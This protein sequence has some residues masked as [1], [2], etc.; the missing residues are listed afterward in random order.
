MIAMIK[1]VAAFYIFWKEIYL[2]RQGAVSR[3]NERVPGRAGSSDLNDALLGRVV[4]E[5]FYLDLAAGR[6]V[7]GRAR[8]GLGVHSYSLDDLLVLGLQVSVDTRTAVPTHT[9]TVDKHGCLTKINGITCIIPGKS[10][11]LSR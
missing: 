10:A 11:V 7:Q 1:I 5:R 3:Q 6:Q 8:L 2:Q 4:G 9:C